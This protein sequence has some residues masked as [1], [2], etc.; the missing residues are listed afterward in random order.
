MSRN[1]LH[2]IG[3]SCHFFASKLCD[4]FSFGRWRWPILKV[5]ANQIKELS[6]ASEILLVLWQELTSLA[7]ET[8]LKVDHVAVEE[9][10]ARA[11][12]TQ[13]NYAGVQYVSPCALELA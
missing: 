12:A 9:H 4:S 13:F 11:F 3:T 5:A 7:K 6:V 8:G 2:I 1:G 10:M